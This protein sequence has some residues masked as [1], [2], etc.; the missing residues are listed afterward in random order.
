LKAVATTENATQDD[1]IKEVD[2]FRGT[3]NPVFKN[4][5]GEMLDH[6]LPGPI[7][8]LAAMPQNAIRN[9]LAE[10]IL[11]G[12]DRLKTMVSEPI[13]GMDERIIDATQNFGEAV[14]VTPYG[15]RLVQQKR[16]AISALSMMYMARGSSMADAIKK[17]S[18]VLIPFEIDG[19]IIAPK[20]TP[21]APIRVA[22]EDLKS[23]LDDIDILL[24]PELD[25]SRA[26]DKLI[27]AQLRELGIIGESYKQRAMDDIVPVTNGDYVTLMW[28]TT[29]NPVLDKNKIKRDPAT[30]E[31]LNPEEA[32]V[33]MP[34]SEVFESSQ[35]PSEYAPENVGAIRAEIS[36]EIG[37]DVNKY[38]TARGGMSPYA[39]SLDGIRRVPINFGAAGK[40][41]TYVSG[42]ED[43]ESLQPAHRKVVSEAIKANVAYTKKVMDRLP[44]S[45][46]EKFKSYVEKSN[47]ASARHF[48]MQRD[49]TFSMQANSDYVRGIGYNY[50]EVPDW[51]K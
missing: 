50:L 24:P 48:E 13:K 12:Q 9:E 8:E 38:F 21:I 40:M 41:R 4:V 51:V 27:P 47:R 18:D 30:G 26:T 16:E 42:K 34:M 43:F 29:K 5:L 7:A 20:G 22:A 46:R 37:I 17:A 36:K 32:T 39:M 25:L 6:E 19:T 44:E 33:R 31:V 2:R 10:A 11:L 14:S 3:Y 45:Q 49:K 28:S 23:R 1:L 15:G 35:E